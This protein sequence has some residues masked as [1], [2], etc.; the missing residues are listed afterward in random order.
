MK[1]CFDM[2]PSL[3]F[4]TGVGIYLQNL[5]R[6]LSEIDEENE[7]I[8][9]SSSWKDRLTPR[10]YGKNFACRDLRIP[11]RLL[12]F[13]WNRIGWPPIE[14]LLRGP[15]D[16][17]HSPTP[18]VIPSRNAH[19]VTTVHDLHFYSHPDEVE[20]EMRRD[21]PALVRK[22]CLRSDA[23]IAISEHT[24]NR[25]IELLKV[26]SSCVYV[27]RH[28]ADPFFA[29]PVDETAVAAT[30]QKLGLEAPYFLF[31]GSAEPRKNLPTLLA[32]FRDLQREALLV[33]AG[34]PGWQQQP[35]KHLL[36]NRVKAA[37]YVSREDLRNLY[38]G[39]VALVLPSRE[40]GFG[41][42]LLEAMSSGT[43]VI[44][45]DIPVFREVCNDSFYSART[46][47]IDDWIEAMRTVY[48]DSSLRGVLADK[49]K[50]RV[51]RYSW[52]ETAE[53]TLDLYRNL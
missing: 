42:P 40:E 17:A 31:V 22:H 5:T 41:L 19:Q 32:A 51:L 4:P 38:R 25:L 20:K 11:V 30:R 16:I 6:A 9:F 3:S 26:P 44:A 21:Y 24:K 49:G 37:G 33:L 12:T 35:W 23:V 15:L 29:Q 7:Y 45:S 8:L 1:I 14:D 52:K 39:A 27:I 13:C 28:G 10:I 34:P 53:R 46:D 47:N 48:D 18:L 36:T 2:R 43:P 50:A